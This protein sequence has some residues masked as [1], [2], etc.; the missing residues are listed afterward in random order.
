[1]NEAENALEPTAAAPSV[2]DEPGSPKAGDSS[3]SPSG[4]CGSTLDR[5]PHSTS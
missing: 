4:G 5:W 1:M 2:S 3:A